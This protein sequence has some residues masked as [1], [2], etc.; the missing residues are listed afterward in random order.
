MSEPGYTVT[1]DKERKLLHMT[2]VGHWD[3]AIFDR[4]EKELR[5]LV[6]TLGPPDT[7]A[8]YGTLVDARAFAVQSQEIAAGFQR[9]AADQSIVL[10]RTAALQPGVLAKM[11]SARMTPGERRRVFGSEVEAVAW[12]LSPDDFAVSDLRAVG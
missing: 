3:A 1:Q 12:L 7:R 2:L 10:G 9:L 6:D 5:R 8:T 11:Q 4:F